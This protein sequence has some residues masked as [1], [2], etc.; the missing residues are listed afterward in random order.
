MMTLIGHWVK[1]LIIIVL[2]GNL[3]QF[4]L[5]KGDLKR[6]AGLIIGL[7]LLLAMIAP[8]WGLIH[9]L[10]NQPASMRLLGPGSSG[11]FQA[12]VQQEQIGQAEAMVLNY[13]QVVSCHITYN[14]SDH[15][16]ADVKT[17]SLVSSET[18][19]TYIMAALAVST[20]RNQNQVKVR[21]VVEHPSSSKKPSP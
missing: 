15:Y 20:G 21:V 17:R 3:A 4:V 9:R 13:P 14:N 2:L 19:K 8:A 6:Y 16:T 1:S 10:E 7:V 11:N 5:P 18:L 12:V